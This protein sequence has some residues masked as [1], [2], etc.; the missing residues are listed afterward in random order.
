MD[1]YRA[2]DVFAFASRSETQGMVLA[3]ALAAGVPAVAVDA[4]GVREAVIDGTNGFLLP[5]ESVS[6]FQAALERIASLAP[7]ELRALHREAARTAE[8]FSMEVCAKR[9]LALYES[10]RRTARRSRKTRGSLWASARRLIAKERKLWANR[11][12]AAG[13]AIGRAG[14]EGR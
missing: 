10:L 13:A 9:A 8:R 4:P 14:P 2:M 5:R 6:A 7:E 3:E 11:A 1:A 12:H